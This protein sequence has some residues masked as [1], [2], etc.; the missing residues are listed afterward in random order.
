MHHCT[1]SLLTCLAVF[2]IE[3][4]RTLARVS[5]ITSYCASSSILA[6]PAGTGIHCQIENERINC[7]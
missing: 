6:W 3:P 2:S 5:V 4:I 1:A 7:T